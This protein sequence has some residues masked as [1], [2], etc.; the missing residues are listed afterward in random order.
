MTRRAVTDC[1]AQTLNSRQKTT[2]ALSRY[3]GAL[4][5]WFEAGAASLKK[6]TS[7]S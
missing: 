1:G 2:E 7:G 3:G 5:P 4:R 6:R